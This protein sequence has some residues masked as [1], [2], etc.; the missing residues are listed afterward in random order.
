MNF[1]SATIEVIPFGQMS[2]IAIF[3]N[4]NIAFKFKATEL[5]NL[6]VGFIVAYSICLFVSV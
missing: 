5:Y 3:I 2:S 6:M 4:E 1:R